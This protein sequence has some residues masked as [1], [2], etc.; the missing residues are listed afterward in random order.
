VL[1]YL[2]AALVALF[3]LW[4][5]TFP[6]GATAEGA[7]LSQVAVLGALCWAAD[8]WPDP[9]RLGGARRLAPQLLVI[10]V[11]LSMFVSPV[12]RAGRAA[13]LLLPAFLMLPAAV[14]RAL[15]D[16]E[17]R[18]RAFLVL[19]LTV[20][21]VAT[22]ALVSQWRLGSPR[23]AM[24]LGHH[25]L[26]AG[27]LVTLLPAVLLPMRDGPRARA[28]S[29]ASALLVVAAVF[30]SGSLL[31]VVALAVEAGLALLWWRR[32]HKLL[33]PSALLVLALQMPRVAK[34][35]QGDDPS[36][37]ARLVYLEAGWKGLVARPWLGWGPG[38]TP[39]TIS[40]Y[41]RPLP[42]VNPPSEVVGDLH[43]LPLQILYELGGL[44]FLF[45]LGTAAIF[46]RRRISERE[47]AEDPD[48]LAAGLIG[49][50]G[51][52]TTRMGGAA[53]SVTALPLAAAVA[54]GIALAAK[55]RRETAGP[56]WPALAYAAVV[57]LALVP[58]DLGH[59]YYE[60]AAR[61]AAIHRNVLALAYVEAAANWDPAFP[62]YGAR[63]AWASAEIAPPTADKARAAATAAV[64]SPVLW[65]QAGVLG[66]QTGR[67][68]SASALERACALDPLAA[69]A[70]FH[71]AMTL[72]DQDPARAARLAARALIAE[73]R[74]LAAHFW[75]GRDVLRAAAIAE[76]E[77]WPGVDPG[78]KEKLVA[79]ARVAQ[80]SAITPTARLGLD[81]DLEPAL[82]FSLYA[83]RRPAWP[84]TVGAIDVDPEAARAVDLPSASTLRSSSAEAFES[85]C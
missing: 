29:I 3:G 34:I 63:S 33:L 70:P 74:L 75:I 15:S 76:V 24:P 73:P 72:A 7:V 82:S 66:A 18:K 9:L 23:A 69:P 40:Q 79:L 42:G 48:L 44:G 83:F 8:R 64:S 36:T 47:S 67:D 68:W 57:G 19:A 84:A 38:S 77:R 14:E 31:G 11:Y 21:A 80:P 62:L 27:F 59:A 58:L 49:M 1:A 26:L 5:G 4:C 46:L 16:T 56:R 41:L 54:A 71:L 61:G 50:L 78:W 51:A 55:P 28:I 20:G 32:F 45:T 22:V 30:R 10:G 81:L 17:R 60:R 43:S 65:L 25:N 2:P 52:A 13:A 53:L 35:F 12:P 39:L 6:G 85:G 37:Q